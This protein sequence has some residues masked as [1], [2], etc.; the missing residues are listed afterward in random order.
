M[1]DTTGRL[2]IG[3]PFT[4]TSSAMIVCELDVRSSCA[5]QKI[6]SQ[7]NIGREDKDERKGRRIQN[8][9]LETIKAN[10]SRVS[11]DPQ[12][13]TSTQARIGSQP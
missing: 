8:N 4:R 9:D 12:C 13:P 1:H 5:C 3:T 2:Y 7:H 6:S 10:D 11:M